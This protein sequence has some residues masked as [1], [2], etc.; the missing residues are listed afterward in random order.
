MILYSGQSQSVAIEK[1]AIH[2]KEPADKSEDSPLMTRNG[3]SSDESNHLNSTS[4]PKVT[5]HH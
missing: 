2:E 4:R 3:E 5:L 1:S